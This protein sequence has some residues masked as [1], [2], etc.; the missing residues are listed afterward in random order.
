M[1]NKVHKLS[2]S[3]CNTLLSKPFRTD[4]FFIIIVVV[5]VVVVVVILLLLLLLFN[6]SNLNA[7]S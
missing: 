1:L 3:A 7:C 4:K 2:N 5:V 6:L